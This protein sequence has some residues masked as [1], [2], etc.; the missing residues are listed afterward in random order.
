MDNAKVVL[1]AKDGVVGGANLTLKDL[2]KAR[3]NTCDMDEFA[4]Y[5]TQIGVAQIYYTSN[6]AEAWKPDLGRVTA[7]SSPDAECCLALSKCVS[8]IR[9]TLNTSKTDPVPF[10]RLMKPYL[11]SNG[12]N[13]LANV[14]NLTIEKV[15]KVVK[16]KDKK[17]NF[18]YQYS[19]ENS[20]KEAFEPPDTIELCVP[21]FD[22]HPDKVTIPVEV[23]FEFVEKS[24]NG[25]M[26]AETIFRF[27]CLTWNDIIAN[28]SRDTILSYLKT[29]PGAEVYY[30]SKSV[31][32]A[33]D[34]YL[35][36]PTPAVVQ[37]K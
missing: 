30:G 34:E 18:S 14:Q 12:L 35:Y 32:V 33:T 1:V 31:V 6:S 5:V 16:M 20:A 8:T 25:V 9:E 28:A 11:C 21:L 17:G 22:Q 27:E 15:T 2:S 4:A 19:R 13:L 3:F 37:V 10:L 36:H 29:V 23:F 26:Y 24:A 7:L